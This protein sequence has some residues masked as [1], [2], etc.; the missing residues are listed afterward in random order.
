MSLYG[1]ESEYFFN[2]HKQTR[3]NVYWFCSLFREAKMLDVHVDG[4]NY[5]MVVLI[6]CRMVTDTKQYA[7][8]VAIKRLQ[9]GLT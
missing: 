1:S 7:M 8:V 2:Y 3:L 9:W 6:N 5:D 4:Y